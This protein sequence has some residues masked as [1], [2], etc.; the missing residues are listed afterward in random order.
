LLALVYV[1][2]AE[3]V[4]KMGRA[5][6]DEDVI[7]GMVGDENTGNGSTY[8]QQGKVFYREW[9]NFGVEWRFSGGERRAVESR[10]EIPRCVG[11]LH[12]RSDDEGK[13]A[14]PLRSE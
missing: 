13:S 12:R 10:R 6:V 2:R 1:R 3:T 4:E 11:R 9:W 7:P 14:G 8:W 5:R